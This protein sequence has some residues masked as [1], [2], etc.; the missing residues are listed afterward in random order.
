MTMKDILTL[1]QASSI[2][3]I[4]EQSLARVNDTQV[5]WA[6]DIKVINIHGHP[7]FRRDDIN[8]AKILR[9]KKKNRKRV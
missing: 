5:T 4:S 7:H 1:S 9:D 3:G 8:K 6:R 2:L